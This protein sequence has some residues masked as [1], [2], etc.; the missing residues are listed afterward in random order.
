[1]LFISLSRTQEGMILSRP[2]NNH[3]GGVLVEAGTALTAPLITRLL[4]AGVRSVGV[5]GKSDI[6]TEESV[7]RQLRKRFEMTRDRPHMALLESIMAGYIQD[8]YAN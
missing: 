3:A 5:V 2:V 8:F 7:L 4:K 1:M 6:A